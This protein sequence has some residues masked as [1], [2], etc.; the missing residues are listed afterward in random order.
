[1]RCARGVLSGLWTISI[2]LALLACERA[3]TVQGYTPSRRKSQC[4]SHE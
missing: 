2:V 3:T 1:M 4:H